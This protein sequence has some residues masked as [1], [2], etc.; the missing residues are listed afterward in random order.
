MRDTLKINEQ[1]AKEQGDAIN[2]FTGGGYG[3]IHDGSDT[4]YNDLIDKAIANPNSPIYTGEQFR[5]IKLWNSDMPTGITTREYIQTII[6]KGLWSENGATSFS[7]HM[8]VAEDFGGVHGYMRGHDYTSVIIKY[9]GH[10]GMPIK[11]ISDFEH[12]KEVLH[13]R[14]QMKRGYDIVDHSWSS[15][16]GTVTITIRDKKRK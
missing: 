2:Y 14:Q 4:Y 10:T 7:A 3:P 16:G 15:D 9:Q 11:H 5:G 12:E 6:D 13:S 8:S 1:D